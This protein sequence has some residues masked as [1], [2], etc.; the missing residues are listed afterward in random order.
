MRTVGRNLAEG[1]GLVILVLFL[2][3]GNIRARGRHALVI[4]WRC[5]SPSRAWFRPGSRPTSCASVPSIRVIVDGAVIITE[6]ALRHVAERQRDLG[7]PL[8]LEERLR[9]VR[10]SA[11][12]MIR[13]SLY[14]QAIIILVYVPLL[15]FTGVEGKLFT[16]MALTVILALAAAFVLSLTFV[17]A[18]SAIVLAGR[19][20]ETDGPPSMP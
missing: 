13:P 3:L 4:R 1:A 20:T 5:C 15:T 16:P 2:M 10:A 14:G 18:L 17:P 8:D 19:V 6:N 9:T 7:R 11:E 12:E